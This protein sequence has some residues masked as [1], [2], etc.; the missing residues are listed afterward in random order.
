MTVIVSGTG[1]V[2]L[3]C[4]NYI[5]VEIFIIITAG[6]KIIIFIKIIISYLLYIKTIS[7]ITNVDSDSITDSG[8]E[9]C[10]NFVF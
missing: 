8:Q 9:R 2:T 10:H 6:T 3:I 1:T 5:S 4:K 7:T